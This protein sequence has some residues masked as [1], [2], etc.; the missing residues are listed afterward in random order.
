MMHGQKRSSY[1]I[2]NLKKTDQC[3]EFLV[4]FNILIAVV[5]K[6]IRHCVFFVYNNTNNCNI[7]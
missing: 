4:T 2:V 1:P 5:K 3:G 6:F 7:L